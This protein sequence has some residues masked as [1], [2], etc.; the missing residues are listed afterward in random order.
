LNTEP[1]KH[2]AEQFMKDYLGEKLR[3]QKLWAV[4]CAPFQERYFRDGY[5]PNDPQSRIRLA[6]SEVVMG[7]TPKPD[8]VEVIT[9]GTGRH[10]RFRYRL[11]GE[12]GRF[13]IAL[14]EMQC[15]FCPRDGGA[16]AD[17]KFCGG[18]GWLALPL[19]PGGD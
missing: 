19:K 6:E 7:I 15:G 9:T 18:A 4:A 11:V 3:L 1:I 17:C 10:H 2:S 13:R 8:F 14:V 12:V 16:K 5:S